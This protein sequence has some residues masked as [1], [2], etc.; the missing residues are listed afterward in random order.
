MK[1]R[2]N[3]AERVKDVID[4]LNVRRRS[5]LLSVERFV[6]GRFEEGEIY[7]EQGRPTY[8]R[9]GDLNGK[10]AL[11]WLTN[12]REVYFAFDKDAPLPT[13]GNLSITGKN[14]HQYKTASLTT[15]GKDVAHATQDDVLTIRT[16]VAYAT[17]GDLLLT[18]KD[19]VYP[20]TG[21]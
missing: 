7:F 9:T 4:L 1:K 16:D 20:T 6:G 21:G 3:S 5:G 11:S 10:D 13:T 14:S 12:W 15:T 17:T 18:D 19:A 8:A 2:E